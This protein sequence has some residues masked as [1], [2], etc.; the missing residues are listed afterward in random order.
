[1]TIYFHVFALGDHLDM[2]DTITMELGDCH[3]RNMKLKYPQIIFVLIDKLLEDFN[4]KFMNNIEVKSKDECW[5][6][7]LCFN[8][9]GYGSF[10][11]ASGATT[12]AHVYSYC[13]NNNLLSRYGK[14]MAKGWI[15]HK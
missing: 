14:P 11:R 2:V 13:L 8:T 9:G 1:M 4:K 15:L 3:N 7:K 6:W 5:N 10:R 12:Q